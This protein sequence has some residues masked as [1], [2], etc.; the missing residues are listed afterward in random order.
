MPSP[1]KTDQTAPANAAGPPEGRRAAD[2][3]HEGR[4]RER[5][6]CLPEAG[7]F[8]EAAVAAAERRGERTVLAEALR[9]LAVV[10][11]HRSEIASATAL[12]KRSYEVARQA[13]NDLLAAEAL[14]TL[15]GLH[16]SAGAPDDARRVFLDAL[17]LCRS[18][19]E[20]RARLG[21]N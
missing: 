1:G 9:R 10:R 4:E 15:G 18:S 12:C 11:R 17:E 8:Y 19:P 13:G 3:L 21:Q 20:G 5:V 14:N 2:L 7:A 6:A 16:L